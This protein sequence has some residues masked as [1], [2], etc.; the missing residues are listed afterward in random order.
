M[1]HLARSVAISSPMS[2][3]IDHVVAPEGVRC[4][5]ENSLGQLCVGSLQT[6]DL[7]RHTSLGSTD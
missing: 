1:W 2:S 4:Q 6:M 3:A 5:M 7:H